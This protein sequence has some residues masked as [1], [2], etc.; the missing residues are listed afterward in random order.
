V[1]EVKTIKSSEHFRTQFV[2]KHLNLRPGQQGRSQLRSRFSTPLVVLMCMVGMV[3]LIACANVANLMIARAAARQKE[4]AIRLAIGASRLQI[5][6]QFLVESTLLAVA[7]GALGLLLAAWTGDGL[8]RFM[9]FEGT[10]QTLSTDPDARVLAFTLALSIL[11]GLLFGLVPAL[12]ST[13]P[14]LAPTLKDES[15]SSSATGGQVR[16]RKGLV[17]AQVALSLLLLIGGGL[18]AKSLYNLKNLNPGFRTDH[19][20]T[21]SVDPS[22]SGYKQSQILALFENMRARISTIPGVRSVSMAEIGMM[23]GSSNRTSVRVEG[24][25]SKEDEDMSPYTNGVGPGYFA[26]LGVPLIAGR[27]FTENDGPSAPKVAIINETMAHY[28]F[29][30]E[31]PLGRHF[32]FGSRKDPKR[33]DIEIIGVV[34]DGKFLTY[35]EKANRFVY[36]PYRQDASLDRMTFYVQTAQDPNQLATAL[37]Q[38]VRQLDAN[39]PVFEVKSMQ[40]QVD[41]SLFNA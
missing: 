40:V 4:V 35:R 8:L 21:F 33:P 7:G 38:A 34:K 16:F 30:M 19:L 5:I 29:G 28:F 20:M 31:N 26:T 2:N 14:N 15:G 23:T 25:Q 17:V 3:L 41:E 36:L 12:Q 39:L 9:P 32:A 10:T 37:R 22:L 1:E 27:D 24:Y 6:R 13:R 11:T 18:F